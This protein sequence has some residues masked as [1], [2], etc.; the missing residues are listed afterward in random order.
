LRSLHFLYFIISDLDLNFLI[1]PWMLNP[2]KIRVLLGAGWLA[3]RQDRQKESK[4]SKKRKERRGGGNTE[5]V[6]EGEEKHA[7]RVN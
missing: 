3:K 6:G 7:W 2:L 4:R 5:R 1:D